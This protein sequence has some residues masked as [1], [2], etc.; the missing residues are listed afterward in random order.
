MKRFRFSGRAAVVCS[1]ILA[2]GIPSVAMGF[3]EGRNLLLGKR[4]PSSNPSLALTSE[5]EIIADT[6]TY[7]TRQSNKKDGD[8]GGAIYGC[9]SSVGNEPCLRASN[10]KGGRA[11]E[12]ST[13]GAEG[14]RIETGTTTG[15]PLTTNATGVATG[16]NADRVDGK[17]AADFAPAADVTTLAA[18]LLDAQVSATGT[19]SAN[20]RGAVSATVTGSTYTVKFNKDVSKCSYTAS[21]VGSA[22]TEAIGVQAATAADSVTVNTGAP[23]PGSFHLQVIC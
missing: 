8:G 10:L 6:A 3:G 19:V 4:N 23:G 11:F 9:R 1:L 17:E 21:P 15:A 14:G 22:A 18:S 13:V 12:F 7:G 5:T 16:L 20:S 2:I